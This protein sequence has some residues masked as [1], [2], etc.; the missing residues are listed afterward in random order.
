MEQ[1]VG[2]FVHPNK[3]AYTYDKGTSQGNTG[4]VIIMIVLFG[5]ALVYL[6][7]IEK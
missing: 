7:L 1:F 4:K 2:C 3:Y 5:A 6:F